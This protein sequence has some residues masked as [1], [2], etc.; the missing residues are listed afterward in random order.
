M[1]G[2]EKE[3][4]TH[5]PQGVFTETSGYDFAFQYPLLYPLNYGDDTV[6]YSINITKYSNGVIST[7]LKNNEYVKA[8][9][10]V[11]ISI[12]IKEGMKL[13]EGSL[14]V[15]GKAIKDMQFVMPQEDVTITAAFITESYI[16]PD[17][18]EDDKKPDEEDN[19]KEDESDENDENDKITTKEP[20]NEE[21]NNEDNDQNDKEENDS[22]KP[23]INTKKPIVEDDEITQETKPV[24]KPDNSQPPQNSDKEENKVTSKP[25]TSKVPK[26]LDKTEKPD[27]KDE[28]QS[29]VII[30]EDNFETVNPLENIKIINKAV[31]SMSNKE[32]RYN[33]ISEL[34]NKNITFYIANMGQS[35]ESII[36]II[37]KDYLIKNGSTLET[38]QIIVYDNETSDY[39]K[40][41]NK[42]TPL[43]VFIPVDSSWVSKDYEKYF[44]LIENGIATKKVVMVRES[45][46]QYYLQIELKNPLT[47]YAILRRRADDYVIPGTVSNEMTG[48][49][50]NDGTSH[51]EVL[52]V[53][54]L[55]LIVLSLIAIIMT[56]KVI[57]MQH[58]ASKIEDNK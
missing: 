3:L 30:I 35:Q 44:Y 32:V 8:G 42:N 29:Q 49:N 1:I 58:K 51:K 56:F 41:I 7:N 39:S 14:K 13:I 57:S 34:S 45:D 46:G 21:N 19:D 18:N 17:D 47:S 25:V 6:L 16:E 40:I 9:S 2:E 38:L 12:D 37:S 27:N 20:E 54:E 33:Y 28:E 50:S 11:S 36:D 15:N 10:V 52:G 4:T 24:V 26:P 31:I 22:T 55:V 23:P 53:R 48:I 43:T 5:V